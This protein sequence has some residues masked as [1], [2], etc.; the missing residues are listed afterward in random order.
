MSTN[1]EQSII[2][3]VRA[4]LDRANHPNTPQPEAETAFTLAQKLITKYN[5][6]ESALL[7]AQHIEEGIEKSHIDIFGSYALRRLCVAGAVARANSC[8][9]YRTQIRDTNWTEGRHG[10][11][12]RAKKGY[13]LYLY[14]TAKDIFATQVLWQAIETLGLRKVPTGDR[15]FK[16]SW[17]HGFESGIT[18]ALS[19]A[20]K[21]IIQD[22]GDESVALVL[23]TRYKRADEEMR[24]SVRLRSARSSGASRTDA[25]HAGRSA[26]ESF[27]AGGLNRGA[28]GA[29]GR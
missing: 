12:V 6:D 21:E 7:D 2:E 16:N 26:G 25:Y 17:W 14:G 11:Y 8:A 4:I 5:L 15:A 27:S 29:I 1:T 24:A 3:K 22:T 18:K 13:R 28:I 19:K 9:N 10:N 20:T 23:R